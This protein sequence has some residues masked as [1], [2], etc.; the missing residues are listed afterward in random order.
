MLDIN[1]F[2]Q[3]IDNTAKNL[4]KRNFELAVS[5]INAAEAQRKQL[6]TQTQKLQNLR[7]I[8][9]KAIGQAKQRGED[10]QALLDE[11]G[12]IGEQLAE[13]EQQLQAVQ[14]QLQTIYAEVPN[15]LHE[16]VPI[17][18]D[19]Q[20]NREERC[21]GELRTFDFTPRDHADLG[22]RDDLMDFSTAAK[23]S[24]AR[25]VVLR[26]G[27]AR[28]HRALA[29]FMLDVHTQEHGYQEVYVPYLVRPDCLY[30]TGQLPKFVDDQ[31]FTRDGADYALLPTAE[32]ALTNLVRE[33]ILTVDQLPLKF[34]AQTPCFRKEAGS[35]GKD[36]RGMIRQHQF[37]KV[38]LVHIVPPEQSY[39]VLEQLVSHAEAI[40]QKLVLPYRVLTLCSGDTGFSA[41]KTY[42][43]EVWLPGQQCYR[44]I[45]SCS[46]CE[47][48]QARRMKAR[49]RNPV[50][51]KTEYVHTL[52]GSGLAVGR[53][54]LAV[55]ENYQDEQGRIVAPDVLKSYMNGVTLI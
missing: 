36:I 45:S 11:V 23:L 53:T 50:T 52:N 49:W 2:R 20:D 42:D 37:E 35:Y 19:E 3:D 26:Q 6:Q 4:L 17:G 46:N 13:V 51:Q 25:F 27:L 54:L 7:N 29:Q 41:A 43:L 40:L 1:L 33:Q 18:K 16:S 12:Q 55:M 31:Y 21:W 28:L 48:F 39:D 9:S 30:G 8:R 47:S 34:V 38:E 22:T 44:E 5:S 15:L 10:V 14:Q 24:G 32:V